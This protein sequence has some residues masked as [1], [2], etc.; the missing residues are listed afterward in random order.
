MTQAYTHDADDND[1]VMDYLDLSN[2]PPASLSSMDLLNFYTLSLQSF[3]SDK[4]LLN[5]DLFRYIT[6]EF[7][8]EEVDYTLESGWFKSKKFGAK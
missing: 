1:S 8:E 5:D 6:P 7:I 2:E 4:I 3:N